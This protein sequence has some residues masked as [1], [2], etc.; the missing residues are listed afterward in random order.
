LVSIPVKLYSTA[1][2]N[3]GVHF[4]LLHNACKGRLK[5]QYVC[6]QHENAVVPRDEMVKGY[7][8]AKDQYVTFTDE[9]LKG[10]EEKSTQSVDIVEFVPADKVPDVYH[11]KSYYL[12]PDK[13]GD[14]AYNLLATAMRKV[15]RVALAQYAARGKQY[16]V[17]VSPFE[18]GLL[19][20]QLYYAD[21]VRPIS[22]VPLS[23][24]EV[25]DKEL[26]LAVALIHQIAKDEFRPEAYEDQVKKRVEAAVQQKVE[27]AEV[28][29]AVPEPKAQI[30]DQMS[31][32]KA[33]LGAAVET[34]TA[35]REAPAAASERKGPKRA[36][37]AAASK[38]AAKGE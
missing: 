27:G 7:E 18:N 11:E 29:V 3:T 23:D 2:A 38:K 13:G 34:A 16:L 32:L 37:R 8:F 1:V 6:P 9:E 35:E 22:E 17:M 30:I 14:R 20:Q 33:S 21:E 19:L 12:G 25:K 28:S 4:N 26:D 31:A 5:Q 24:A 15:G 10:L 36:T